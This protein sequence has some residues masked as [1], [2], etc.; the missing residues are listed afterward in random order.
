LFIQDVLLSLRSSH[1][2]ESPSSQSVSR[3]EIREMEHG[4]GEGVDV[5]ALN[6]EMKEN[7]SIP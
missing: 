4:T 5:L 1:S 6:G 3:F 7:I 2:K